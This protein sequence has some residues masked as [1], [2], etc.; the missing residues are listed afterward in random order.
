MAANSTYNYDYDKKEWM[1]CGQVTD[2]ACLSC[3]LGKSMQVRFALLARL[4]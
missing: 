1:A 3:F 4:S 2:W